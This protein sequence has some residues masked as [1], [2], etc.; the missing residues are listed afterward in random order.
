MPPTILKFG[1][2][3]HRKKVAMFDFDWTLVK[4]KSGGTFPKNTEDWV[5]LRPN[6]PEIVKG[7]FDKGFGI[8]IYT[9]QSKAWKQDQITQV[10]QQLGVPCTVAI[11]FDK[12]E[13]K[14]NRIMFDTVVGDK[15]FDANTSFFVGDALGRAAD[16]S[17]SDKKFAEAIGVKVQAPEDIFPFDPKESNSKPKV[18]ARK[19]Q[20][21]VIVMVGYPGSGK[22]TVAHD[23]FGA[24][25]YEVID[26]DTLK[27]TS[28]MINVAKKVVSTGVSVVFDATNPTI[29]KRAEYIAFANAAGLPVRC[30]HVATS[31]EEAVARNNTRPKEKGIPMIA[32][33]TYRKRFEQPTNQEGCEVI[34][35]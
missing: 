34:V 13:H 5:W 11:A 22:S 2:P 9:N 27:T 35:I 18:E 14:P 12:S 25:G 19:D 7:F 17:D 1:A 3:R 4:P 30:I 8:H 6:V 15:A 29:A 26:G 16:F 10:A 20:Q 31:M 28:K 32:Y 24:K 23:V 21:E 33:Y